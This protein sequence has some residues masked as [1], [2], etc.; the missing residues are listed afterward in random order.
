MRATRVIAGAALL[1][2][3]TACGQ[4]EPAASPGSGDRTTVIEISPSEPSLGPTVTLPDPSKAPAPPIDVAPPAEP[5]VP[6]G[7][8]LLPTS[9]VDAS[10][11]P[12]YYAD[13]NVWSVNDGRTLMLSAM[14]RTACAGVQARVVEQSENTVRINIS[15]MDTPQGGP[16]DG[17]GGPG[18][19]AQ[20]LTPKTL[21]VDL[22]VPLG[23]RKVVLT[24]AP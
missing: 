11:L 1:L 14:A 4:A 16:A 6:T 2:A 19:C 3:L 12:T 15:P 21:T 8:T 20:V 22:K 9:Q 24:E 5:T 7:A 18:M 10:G 23:K 13:R 17:T